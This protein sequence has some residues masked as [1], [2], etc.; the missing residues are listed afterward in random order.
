MKAFCR[1]F[2]VGGWALVAAGCA[3]S[4]RSEVSRRPSKP[5]TLYSE[6][7]GLSCE[8][9]VII[10]ARTE[11]GGIAAEYSWLG[12]KYPGYKMQGLSVG[13]CGAA[14]DNLVSITT[15]DGRTLVIHFD[16]SSFIQAA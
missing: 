10:H 11:P 7:D 4:S 14:V 13:Q 5:K 1:L 8:T 2:L 3:T 12:E 9:R 16:I 6:A 15:A